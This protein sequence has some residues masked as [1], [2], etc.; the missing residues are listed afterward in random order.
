M[1]ANG[2]GT[3][4]RGEA[5]LRHEFVGMMFAVTV[6]EVGLQVAPLV[7]RGSFI[8]WLPA[9]SHILL[10][11]LVIA[12]SWVGWSLSV[13]PG[14]RK[15][16]TGVFQWE[17]LLLL[18]DVAMVITYF[19]L[20]RTV[21][22]A[23]TTPRIASAAEVAKWILVIFGLYLAWDFVTKVLIYRRDR[24]ANSSWGPEGIRGL[25]T[26]V[27]F[28]LAA[29]VWRE[30][31]SADDLHRLVVDLALLSL[32]LLFRASKDLVSGFLPRDGQSFPK[33]LRRPSGL[34]VAWV[35]VSAIGLIY[36]TLATAYSLPL[37]L[38]ND[39]IRS[40]EA[41]AV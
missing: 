34:T 16:V 12:M 18:L 29:L 5:R 1:A 11:T 4:G 35:V 8:H 10:A 26:L 37:P 41:P 38:P 31:I 13:S 17:F 25:P 7:Q 2:P 23:G 3:K 30:S 15:D 9:Y 28:G 27:C 22:F 6:G 40:I 33:G 24:D 14:A 20:V 32:V 36:A 21:D 39:L 19:I